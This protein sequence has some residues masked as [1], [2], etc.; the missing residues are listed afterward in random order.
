[1]APA[2]AAARI[3]IASLDIGA[4]PETIVIQNAGA[5]DQDMT[6]WVI[7]SVKGNQQYSF[8]AGFVLKAGAAVTVQSASKAQD[9]PPAILRWATSNIW[10]N[11]GDPAELY[12]SSGALVP[13]TG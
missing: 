9:N 12:D 6:G 5:A 2:A 10:N 8:P 3:V 4:N 11:D 1:V 13:Q 7:R